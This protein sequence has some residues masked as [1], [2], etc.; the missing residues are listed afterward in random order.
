VGKVRKTSAERLVSKLA[1]L[2]YVVEEGDYVIDR[3]YGQ[4]MMNKAAGECAPT[5]ALLINVGLFAGKRDPMVRFPDGVVKQ[6]EVSSYLPLLHI[7]RTPLSE[8]E[9]WVNPEGL[10]DRLTILTSS[11]PES[12]G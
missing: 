2:G 11:N 8:W 9:I 7:L 3:D 12:W 5:W 10:D 1:K 6:V 4:P